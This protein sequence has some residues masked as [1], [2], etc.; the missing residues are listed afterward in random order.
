MN[1]QGRDHDN[2]AAQDEA[3]CNMFTDRPVF[4]NKPAWKNFWQANNA[5]A[6]Y[7]EYH[8]HNGE[9]DG[10]M[11]SRIRK[12]QRHESED[13]Q[14]LKKCQQDVFPIAL[15]EKWKGFLQIR[16]NGFHIVRLRCFTY[17]FLAIRLS[18]NR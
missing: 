14:T 18:A 8:T 17:G 7:R 5:E 9:H 6:H 3:K 12:K 1:Q 11:M 2:D 13:K 16:G 4:G 10:K 15:E